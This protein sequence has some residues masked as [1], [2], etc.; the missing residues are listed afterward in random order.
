MLFRSELLVKIHATALNPVDW[1]IREYAYF[2]TE[3]PAVLGTDSAGTV[4]EVGEG[5]TGFAKGDKV[6]VIRDLIFPSV[7]ADMIPTAGSIKGGSRM[8][9]RRSSNIPLSQPKSQLK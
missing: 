6:C 4:E 7:V 8:I 3:Y 1:K 5:V 2:I 9:K